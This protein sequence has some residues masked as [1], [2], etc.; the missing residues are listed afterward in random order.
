MPAG[1]DSTL[2][3]ESTSSGT[4]SASVESSGESDTPTRVLRSSKRNVP[5]TSIKLTNKRTRMLIDEAVI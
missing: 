4:R 3:A 5:T 1:K 2:R